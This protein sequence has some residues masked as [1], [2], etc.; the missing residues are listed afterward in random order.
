MKILRLLTVL[1]IAALTFAACD[2]TTEGIGGSITNKI[3]NI[4][5]SNSAFNVTTKSIVADSVLSRNNTGLIGKMK[6]PETGNY[7][8][9][10][11]MTQLSVLPTF[12]VDTL[13][14]IKQANNG[15]IEADSCYLLVSYNAS[16]GDT[17]APMKVTAYEMTKPMAED[18]EYYSNYDAF[19]EGWVSENNPH[20]S[21]NYNLSNTSDVKNFKI[22]LN[23]KYTKDG[24]TYKNYGSY[25]MQTYAEHPEYFKTNY[26]FL[27]NVCPGFYIKNVGGTGNM[28]KIW[29]TELI[30]Y[31]TRH[32]T[33]NK[34]STAVSIGYNR[35]DGTEEVLQLNKIEN[36]TENLKKLASKDQ[37]KCT[38][39]KSPAG[40]FTEVT[41]P[42]EDIMKGHE[43]DTL[44]TA[45]ISFPRLNNE[46]E[47]NP[48]N[49]ATPSTILMVQKDSLQSFFEKSKLADSR[50][51]YT[52]SYSS[53]GTY[54][55]AY[56]FQN[57]ANLVSAM[58]KNKGK[59][60][61]WNKVVLVPVNV[62]TT[63][64]GYTTV[65]S[66]IN[67]DMSLAS[68]RLIVGTDDSDKDYTTDEKTGKKVASGPI[69]IKVIYS[70]FKEE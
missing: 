15:S 40:I 25:I 8:K 62:I 35:F 60:E 70:K 45:T 10:D 58:Y 63:T 67:H 7:V 21:S 57:I 46:N 64:Q 43:K 14:Y 17:I 18:K 38:Y 9:G 31:W 28:A 33:I 3:D 52:A 12:S 37:E 27:H 20:W 48:Y 65:I 39:L 23:K 29:N 49:F 36:D 13:D 22:Y 68:T 56:T 5:I 66:K 30:F 4:N 1:V 41:L 16:Y 53:T 32:K 24:K 19:K 50:T 44:N 47:D 34:D 61:N 54:K 42:I 69:R 26:K 59:G 6:D 55:N 51:S 2:D 11:Y